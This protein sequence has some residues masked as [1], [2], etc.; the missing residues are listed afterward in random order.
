MNLVYEIENFDYF[1][2]C[3]T[4]TDHNAR[5][6]NKRQYILEAIKKCNDKIALKKSLEIIPIIPNPFINAI[7]LRLKELP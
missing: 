7:N 5:I 6:Q 3:S 1:S 4:N 2:L